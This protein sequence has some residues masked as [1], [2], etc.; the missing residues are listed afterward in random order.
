[1][2]KFVY[3]TVE[4]FKELDSIISDGQLHIYSNCILPSGCEPERTRIGFEKHDDGYLVLVD[5][6]ITTNS[7]CSAFCDFLNNG[8]VRFNTITELGSFFNSLQSLFESKKETVKKHSTPTDTSDVVDK[9]KLRQIRDE[10]DKPKKVWPEEIAEPLKKKVFGQD[11][12]ID[13]IAKKIAINKIRKDNTLLVIALL[14]P[15]ATGK[16]ETA[17]LLAEIMSD[18]YETKYD[19]IE[20]AASEFIGEH[21]VHRFFGA[22]PGYI[23]HGEPTIFEPIRNNPHH[24][25]VL[26][27]IEKADQKLLTGLMEVIDTGYIEL[28]DN[29]KPIDLNQCVMFFT[30][31]IP[32]DMDKYLNLPDFERGEF[33]RDAFTKHC[34][35]PEISGKIGNFLAFS[36]LSDDAIVDIIVKFVAEELLSYNLTLV[37]IDE[38]LMK[39]FMSRQTK[40]GARGIRD[41]VKSSIGD[42]LLTGHKL[43]SLI[44]KKV[45]LN[46]RIEKIEFEIV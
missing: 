11:E 20:V 7:N 23:G 46:G 18:V 38:N 39:D 22:P 5:Y 30:S 2:K 45:I 28:A 14:G 27:E 41:L 34:G 31:N 44:N 6:G 24:I 4:D 17:K 42:Y 1:M 13:S 29:S 35:R 8:E 26:N 16:S 9:D 33:C 36:P 19:L 43:D 32:I 40:Y 15:T 3:A 21:T 37:H 25:I 12:V 10:E